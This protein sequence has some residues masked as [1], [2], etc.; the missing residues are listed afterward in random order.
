MIWRQRQIKLAENRVVAM[1]NGAGADTGFCSRFHKLT[2]QKIRVQHLIDRRFG[3]MKRVPVKQ[4][5]KQVKGHGVKGT[6]S[7]QQVQA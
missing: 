3:A 6:H 7:V 5:E 1:K 4:H 2:R